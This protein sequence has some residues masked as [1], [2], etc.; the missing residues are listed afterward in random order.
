MGT[1]R[2]LNANH[3]HLSA[4]FRQPDTFLG[5]VEP[6]CR[7]SFAQDEALPVVAA[8]EA[9]KL[10]IVVTRRPLEH[11][12]DVSPPH[13]RPTDDQWR[14]AR[15]KYRAGCHVRRRSAHEVLAEAV[16]QTPGDEAFVAGT[17]RPE[18]DE[19]KIRL[20]LARCHPAE[21]STPM[22][23]DAVPHDLANEPADLIEAFDPVELGHTHGV[24]VPA[25]LAHQLSIQR[26]VGLA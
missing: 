8:Q 15:A 11:A 16:S 6:P 25:H 3:S 22:A 13:G 18:M 12:L 10:L 5:Y 14:S 7:L 23:V 26:H 24:L 2:A 19:T 4:V 1:N 9:S 21:H 17:H 20:I